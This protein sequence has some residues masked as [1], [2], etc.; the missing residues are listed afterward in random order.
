MRVL[1]HE[2]AS[3]SHCGLCHLVLGSDF[4]AARWSRVLALVAFPGWWFEW[5]VSNSFETSTGNG[6]N[7]PG[8]GS[9][10]L[11]MLSPSQRRLWSRVRGSS[12]CLSF[13]SRHCCVRDV[14]YKS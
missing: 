1:S 5:S 8:S 11:T 13:Q 6:R 7:L 10:S 2:A 3:A 14:L 12:C 9:R 4:V